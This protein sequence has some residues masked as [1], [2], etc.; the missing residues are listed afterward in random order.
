NYGRGQRYKTWDEFFTKRYEKLA[1]LA[2]KNRL[3]DR[4]RELM[5]YLLQQE[6]RRKKLI[7]KYKRMSD[8][9]LASIMAK[10]RTDRL[11]DDLARQG[12]N[13]THKEREEWLDDTRLERDAYD[14]GAYDEFR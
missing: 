6:M 7:A 3:D 13:M 14:G 11:A 8:E 2:K 9:E 12:E 5:I 4:G 10:E 1:D